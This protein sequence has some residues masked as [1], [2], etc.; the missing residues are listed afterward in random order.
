[1]FLFSFTVA[2]L[3]GD[4]LKELG[5]T[6]TAADKKITN[7]ILAGSI[8]VYGVKNAVNLAIGNRNAVTQDLLVYTKKY[9]TTDVFKKEYALLKES[10]KPMQEKI[11]SPEEMQQETIAQYK[12]GV[13]D[14]EAIIKKAD[15]SLKPTFEK[16]LAESKKQLKEAESPNNKSYVNYAKNYP[17]FLKNVEEDYKKLLTDWE[18]K[19]PA[20]HMLFVKQRLV[21]F[22]EETKDIDFM[23]ALVSKNGKKVFVNKN[24]ESKSSRWK[25]A[26]RAGKEVVMPARAFVEQWINEIK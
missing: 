23:A 15:A 24:Y 8:D 4:F 19:Y 3:N 11:K 5:I 17:Q 10:N 13:S 18:N 7:S 16:A 14:M 9:V 6:K 21:Q 20:N 26:F 25:M 2:R 22:L 1:L 12:K